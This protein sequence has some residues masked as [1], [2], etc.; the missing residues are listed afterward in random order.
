M[1]KAFFALLLFFGCAKFGPPPGGPEDKTPPV[2]V[3]TRPASGSTGVDS[4][5]SFEIVFSKDLEREGLAQNVFISPSLADS[6]HDWFKGKTYRLFP[7]RYLKKGMTYVLTLGT[8]IRDRH[9]N[10]LAQAYSFSF[11]TG[12]RIDSGQI[13]GQVFDQTKPVPQTSV[14]IFRMTDTL[15]VPDW[16][17]PDYQTSSGQDG[18]FRFSFLPAGRYRILASAGSKFA[19]Y[20]RDLAAARPGEIFPP[21]QLFLAPLDT[22]AMTLS[23]V[24]FNSDRILTLTFSRALEFSD[25]LP[26]YFQLAARAPAETL[27]L[28]SAFLYPGQK[29]KLCLVVDFPISE[30]EALVRFPALAAR[31][32]KGSVDSAAFLVGAK[33]DKTPPRLVMSEPTDRRERV[34]LSDT[35]KFYFSEPVAA[36]FETASPGLFDSFK[37][38]VPAVWSQPQANAFFFVPQMPLRSGEWYRFRFP[39]AS[40]ADRAGN[41]LADSAALSF[42]TYFSDSLG[43][44]SGRLAGKSPGSVILEF[45]ELGSGWTKS[46]RVADSA[47]SIPL[48]SGKYFLSG[49]VD[50][51]KDKR[52]AAGGLSP[53]R[54]PEPAFFYPDTV[55]VRARFETEGIEVRIP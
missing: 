50:E 29:E 2:V 53:F 45:R 46:E 38:S 15:A 55:F 47:F 17:N 28:R 19:L 21:V 14:R 25:T 40:V 8:G 48:L 36:R 41:L 18:R 6:F 20:H 35:L 1:K 37:V 11:S 52:R 44:V 10:P 26:A 31:W 54:F 51:N 13:T 3:S 24:R 43:T 27:R 42:R 23:E 16:Q 7:N 9:G 5:V 22:A 32:G 39:V 34:G 33:P 4:A 12:D 30:R 49:F